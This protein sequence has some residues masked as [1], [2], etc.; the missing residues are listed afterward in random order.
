MAEPRTTIHLVRHGEVENP[1]HLH[2][3][4]IPGFHLSKN[5]RAMASRVAADL[6]TRA[7]RADVLVASPLERAQETAAPISEALGLPIRTDA[8]VIE[9]LNHFAGMRINLR[10]LAK[11]S[12]LRHLYNPLRPSWG[13]PFAEIADRMMEA[14]N[15]LR[16]ELPGGE[17][18]V[19][20]H[21][22]PVW[23]ARMRAEGRSLRSLPRGR[24]CSLASVT[25][26]VWAGDRLVAVGYREPAADLLP[27]HL[28]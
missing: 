9:A 20:S 13:E 26:L 25:S 16:A 28:R 6:A 8:R 22:S 17:A 3:E 23:R 1:D 19:V 27:E 11:P 2:Y 5:G 10:N 24:A 12:S 18:I 14:I 4:R 15:D 7:E 21:Q